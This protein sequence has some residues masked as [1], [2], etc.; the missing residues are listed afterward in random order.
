M[1]DVQKSCYVK[2]NDQEVSSNDRSIGNREGEGAF[3]ESA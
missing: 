1:S 3:R 2:L